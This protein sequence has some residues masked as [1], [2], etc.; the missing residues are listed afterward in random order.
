MDESGELLFDDLAGDGGGQRD[1]RVGSSALQVGHNEKGLRVERI[2]RLEHTSTARSQQIA[3][4]GAASH[5]DPVRIGQRQN[6]ASVLSVR[7]FVTVLA[8]PA[9]GQRLDIPC[10]RQFSGNQILQETAHIIVAQASP[11][12]QECCHH[13]SQF[14]SPCLAG[15]DEHMGEPWRQRQGSQRLAMG[16][17]RSCVIQRAEGLQQ[18]DR[19]GPTGC[20][21][22]IQPSEIGG[23]TLAPKCQIQHKAGEICFKNF[24]RLE[25]WQRGG[26]PLVP[27]T[28]ANPRLGTTGAP[29]SLIGTGAG[30][31]HR[32]PAAKY[33]GWAQSEG[34]AQGPHQ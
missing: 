23:V 8:C 22:F 31:A 2:I 1:A 32:S 21:R 30:N 17:D 3:P 29:L 26:L 27:K 13:R 6:A 25:G 16:R 9:F 11:L 34:V 19:F 20:G 28:I 33:Q 15:H 10:P 18:F 24:R 4:L 5:G 14:L 7:S 12:A